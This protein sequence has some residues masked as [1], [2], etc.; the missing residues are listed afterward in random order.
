MSPLAPANPGERELLAE[1]EKTGVAHPLRLAGGRS[2]KRINQ[3][4]G[5]AARGQP[6][7]LGAG[8]RPDRAGA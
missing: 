4:E 3:G 2:A 6:Q 7:V 8:A 1:S 5:M